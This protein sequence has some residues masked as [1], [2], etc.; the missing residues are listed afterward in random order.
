MYEFKGE[1]STVIKNIWFYVNYMLILTISNAG[2]RNNGETIA[3]GL[4][5]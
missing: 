1:V 2:L 4:A 5:F 3:A